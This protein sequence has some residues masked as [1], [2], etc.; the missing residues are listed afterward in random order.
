MTTGR[1]GDAMMA[2]AVRTQGAFQVTGR[3]KLF[4]GEYEAGSFLD[5][6]YGV[7]PDGKSFFMFRRVTGTGQAVV[8]TLNWFDQLRAGRK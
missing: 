5:Q 4:T 8:V 2:A 1:A 6:N 3:T 7:A